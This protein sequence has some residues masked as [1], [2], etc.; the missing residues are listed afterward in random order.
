[1]TEWRYLNDEKLYKIYN[2]GTVYSVKSKKFINPCYNKKSNYLIIGLVI[3]NKNT[4]NVLHTLIYKTFNTDYNNKFYV[5]HRD[6]DVYNNILINLQL[7]KRNKPKFTQTLLDNEWKDI[8]KYENRYLIN[9]NGDIKSLLTNTILYDKY[10]TQYEQSYKS[11]KLIN[12]D[13]VRKSYLV[14]RLVYFTFVGIIIDNMVID[15]INQNKFDNRL[16]NLR[17]I[18][19]AQNSINYTKNKKVIIN[20]EIF[21]DNF[22]NINNLYKGYD[23]SNYKINDYGQLKNQHNKNLNPATNKLYKIVV[24]TDKTTK[25]R[26]NVRIHQ[27]VATIFLPNPNN[28]LI[29][30]HKDNNRENNNI[31]NLEWVTHTQNINFSQAKKIG[32]FTLNDKLIKEFNSVNDVF[33]ELNKKYGSNIGKVCNGERKTAFGYKWKWIE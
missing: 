4:K 23:F 7:I 28:Y 22:K 25:K 10:N 15:H 21:T 16:E 30:H 13:G 3:N 2:N 8:P 31:L 14:H 17:Q 27:L 29:V 32:Q 12:N 26:Y 20:E 33:K 9:K 18:T 19:Q 24:L 1:M 6:D 11:I 5:K